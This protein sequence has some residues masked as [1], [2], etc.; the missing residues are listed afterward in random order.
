MSEINN[1]DNLEEGAATT[2]P[3]KVIKQAQ[4]VLKRRR[5]INDMTGDTS[6]QVT[7]MLLKKGKNLNKKQSD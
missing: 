4:R 5:D 2:T 6:E 1:K 7:Q 3:S